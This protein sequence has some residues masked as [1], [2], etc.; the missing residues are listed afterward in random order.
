MRGA[1][2]PSFNRRKTEQSRVDRQAGENAK[3]V[4]IRKV[5]LERFGSTCLLQNVW[6]IGAGTFSDC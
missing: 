6:K 3:V 4:P 5:A 2:A 1:A